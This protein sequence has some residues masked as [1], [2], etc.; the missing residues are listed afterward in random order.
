M[1]SK[2]VYNVKPWLEMFLPYSMQLPE[3]ISYKK[4]EGHRGL[5]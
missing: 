5:I 3:T 1:D 2:G 4:I